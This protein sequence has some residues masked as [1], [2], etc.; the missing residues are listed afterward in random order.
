MLVTLAACIP[1]IPAQAC[2]GSFSHSYVVLD[3]PPSGL[4]KD[5]VLLRVR[6]IKDG[7]FFDW[8]RMRDGLPARVLAGGGL[9]GKT[10][11][12]RSDIW[13]SCSGLGPDE[14]YVV[15][16][17][18]RSSGGGVAIDTIQ[19]RERQYRTPKEEWSRGIERPEMR[20]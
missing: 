19:Y 4:P 2:R 11:R 9:S 17:L 15:G 14:G 3:H 7:R 20:R 5:A 13:T 6:L 8:K 1:A 10:V 18:D 12:L 16:Y